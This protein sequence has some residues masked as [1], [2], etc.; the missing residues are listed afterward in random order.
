MRKCPVAFARHRAHCQISSTSRRY[1]ANWWKSFCPTL[2]GKTLR[3][4]KLRIQQTLRLNKLRSYDFLKKRNQSKPVSFDV[5]AVARYPNLP[6]QCRIE[7]YPKILLT[8]LRIS[9]LSC[10]VVAGISCNREVYCTIKSIYSCIFPGKSSKINMIHLSFFLHKSMKQKFYHFFVFFTM[11]RCRH[12]AIS[13]M[14]K[15]RQRTGTV[16]LKGTGL[17]CMLPRKAYH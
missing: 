4:K 12:D 15:F 3:V 16:Q 6:A 2:F 11:S 10:L 1:Q 14:Q 8:I 9:L 17:F 13:K 7:H 5:D